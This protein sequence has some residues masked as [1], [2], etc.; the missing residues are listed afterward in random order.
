MAKHVVVTPEELIVKNST[1][2]EIIPKVWGEE[3]IIHSDH[4]YCIKMMEVI[5]SYRVSMHWHEIKNE[6]FILLEGQLVIETID[7]YGIKART[8]LD[9]PYSTFTIHNNVPHTFYSPR[10]QKKATF[11]LE[12]SSYDDP[13]DSYRIYPSGKIDWD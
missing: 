10:E 3:D 5:P 9:E 1:D 12:V 13:K 4:N 8:L 2:I 6:T 7:K 11:F